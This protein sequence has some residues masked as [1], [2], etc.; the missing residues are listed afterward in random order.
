MS[1]KL[2]WHAY[3]FLDSNPFWYKIAVIK[4]FEHFSQMTFST[5]EVAHVARLH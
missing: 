4:I 1:L 2:F 3:A 5:H